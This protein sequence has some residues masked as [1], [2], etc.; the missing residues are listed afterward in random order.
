MSDVRMKMLARNV[1]LLAAGVALCAAAAG[2]NGGGGGSGE[3]AFGKNW[4]LQSL[5]K[6]I[7]GGST[8]SHDVAMA[9]DP[10]DADRRRQG[11]ISLSEKDWGLKEPYLKG[12]AAIL[13]TDQDPMVRAAAVRALGKAQ[14]P[15]Y[16]G[17]VARSLFDRSDA[18]RQD[19]AT[20]LDSLVGDVAVNPLRNRAVNDDNQ[21]VRANSAKALRHYRRDDVVRTL[22]ECL[23]DKA[24]SVRYRAHASLVEL[25]GQ[26]LGYD[27]QNWAGV[28]A[29]GLPA[30]RPPEPKAG[31]WWDRLWRKYRKPSPKPPGEAAPAT[32]PA[33]GKAAGGR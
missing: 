14:D 12:Y 6:E 25:T 20:A 3:G 9:F 26:D 1:A 31:N 21:D 24:F 33:A 29:K 23:S 22:V 16:V 32:K 17:D 11:I 7:T 13:Q 28:A 18:V 27:A 19:A 2:C 4:T 8:P 30:A 15:N 5:Y 10:N